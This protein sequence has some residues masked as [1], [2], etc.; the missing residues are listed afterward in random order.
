MAGTNLLGLI[1]NASYN[2]HMD[3]ETERRNHEERHMRL[4][5]TESRRVRKALSR[6]LF[7]LLELLIVIAIIAMLCSLLLPAL[8]KARDTAKQIACA[9]NLKQVYHAQMMYQLDY[10]E[11]I[12]AL[13]S[14]SGWWFEL[15]SGT[16]HKGESIGMSY[17]IS[18]YGIG[19]T[20]GT[21]VC[22]SEEEKFTSVWGSGISFTHY[23]LT[24][25]TGY[26]GIN[27]PLYYRRKMMAITQPSEAFLGSD[28]RSSANLD[29]LTRMVYR[30]GG[31]GDSRTSFSGTSI[32]A[33]EGQANM[34]YFDGH[35]IGM[36]Y[37]D[38]TSYLFF[39][40][41]I[42]VNAGVYCE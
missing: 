34:L 19:V 29:C 11:W 14:S 2:Q 4:R 37:W 36:R 18:Y 5:L 40:A 39:K 28:I 12:V 3:G 30:H 17:G 25:A 35:T 31:R 24:V 7:T 6:V 13:R 22:P 10:G 42:N 8:G 20:K 16:N 41:G 27:D 23:S 9:N 1:V 26:S 38:I 21:L 33:T 15:L 32:P